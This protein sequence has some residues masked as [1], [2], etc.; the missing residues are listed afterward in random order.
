LKNRYLI[1]AVGMPLDQCKQVQDDLNSKDSDQHVWVFDK[2]V[3]SDYINRDNYQKFIISIIGMPIE[4]TAKIQA[5]MEDPNTEQQ[6]WVVNKPTTI[7]H[8][9][10]G[11][12]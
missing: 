9:G 4:D 10:W 3:S 6:Y 2:P 11:T 5:E 8:L 12:Q 7:N 1:S